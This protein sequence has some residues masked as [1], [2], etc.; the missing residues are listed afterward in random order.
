[1]HHVLLTTFREVVP[2]ITGFNTL[3]EKTVAD[4]YALQ[5]EGARRVGNE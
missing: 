2:Q 4:V 5:N 1:M 3:V